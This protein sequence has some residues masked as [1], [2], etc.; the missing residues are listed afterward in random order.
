[1]KGVELD[2]PFHLQIVLIFV[3]QI[4]GESVMYAKHWTQI[5]MIAWTRYICIEIVIYLSSKKDLKD[6]ELRKFIIIKYL[7]VL[8]AKDPDISLPTFGAPSMFGCIIKSTYH[9]YVPEPK[10]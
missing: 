2:L 1:M 10:S 8:L 9:A 5:Y 6:V 3:F 4:L 7:R